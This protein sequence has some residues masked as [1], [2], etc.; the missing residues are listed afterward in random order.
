MLLIEAKTNT[1]CLKPNFL[2]KMM[3]LFVAPEPHIIRQTNLDEVG[4]RTAIISQEAAIKRLQSM[5]ELA[6]YPTEEYIKVLNDLEV[7]I[8][9]S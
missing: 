6:Q 2:S 7:L 4:I 3:S 5:K 9:K 8:V 1:L